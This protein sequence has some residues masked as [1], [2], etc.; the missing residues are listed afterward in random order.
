VRL[1][2]EAQHTRVV[3]QQT[4]AFMDLWGATHGGQDLH[5][6]AKVD[7]AAAAKL[8]N[9]RDL[10]GAEEDAFHELMATRPTTK[11]G[12]IACLKHVAECGLATAEIRAWLT[13]LAE[14][15]LVA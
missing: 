14:S 10:E 8:Q 5:D 12:A 1:A 13:M 9:F 15:P 2:A 6:R 7:K 3:T 4:D 11:A